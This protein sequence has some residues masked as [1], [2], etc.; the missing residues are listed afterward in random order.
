NQENQESYFSSEVLY[1]DSILDK[2]FL[3]YFGNNRNTLVDMFS[4]EN[5]TKKDE[6]KNDENTIGRKLLDWLY[7]GNYAVTK[8]ELVAVLE[9]LILSEPIMEILKLRH[10]SIQNYFDNELEE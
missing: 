4:V 6:N 8:H 7:N 10:Q 3:S 5:Y 9:D 2:R 1:E